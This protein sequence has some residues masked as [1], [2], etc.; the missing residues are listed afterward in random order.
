[1]TGLEMGMGMVQLRDIYRLLGILD[2]FFFKNWTLHFMF[3][4]NA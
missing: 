4:M 2:I 3:L 1:V